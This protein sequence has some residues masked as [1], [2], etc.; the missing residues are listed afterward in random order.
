MLRSGHTGQKLS[1]LL[2]IKCSILSE[3]DGEKG[4]H[5]LRNN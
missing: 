2:S 4:I 1:I 3:E 5:F